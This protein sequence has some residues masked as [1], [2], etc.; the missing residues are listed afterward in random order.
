VITDFPATPC[1]R[2]LP[3]CWRIT[4]TVNKAFP[5]FS[6]WRA[7]RFWTA[8]GEIKKH[9]DLEENGHGDCGDPE[10]DV[11]VRE[12]YRQVLTAMEK[13]EKSERD[14]LSLAISADLSYREIA[15]IAGI[16][17]EN[18]RVK[19]HRARKKLRALIRQEE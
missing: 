9:R 2:V 12:E 3:G 8:C 16:S 13:L 7:T 6:R 18:V 17:E 5:F 4:E 11:L 1:R 10:A 19:I 14:V 15:E